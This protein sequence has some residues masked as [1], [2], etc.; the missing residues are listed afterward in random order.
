LKIQSLPES[1]KLV[2]DYFQDAET[3]GQ[4]VIKVFSA[5]INPSACEI[6]DRSIKRALDPLGILNLEKMSLD[7]MPERFSRQFP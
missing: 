3:A 7:P 5:G 6:L 1:R 4:A 2:L